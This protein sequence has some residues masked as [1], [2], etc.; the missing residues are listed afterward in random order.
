[1][2]TE[3]PTVCTVPSGLA[4]AAVNVGV[5]VSQRHPAARG[6]SSTPFA[7][8]ASDATGSGPAAVAS[9]TVTA[10][11]GVPV[12]RNVTKPV[13]LVDAFTVGAGAWASAPATTSSSRTQHHKTARRVID[14]RGL[15]HRSLKANGPRGEC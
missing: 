9:V 13:C 8:R 14:R 4:N 7:G 1:V 12:K 2:W 5:G 6:S 15:L 10:A 11:P 3:V